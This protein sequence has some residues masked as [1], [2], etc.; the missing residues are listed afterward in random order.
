MVVIS[1][2]SGRPGSADARILEAIETGE[3]RLAISDQY[4][5][6]L[7]RVMAKPEVSSMV[8]E[9]PDAPARLFRT[10]MSIGLMGMLERPR[11]LDWPNLRDPND[12]W[13]LDLALASGADFIV[14]RDKGVLRDAPKSSFEALTP[15]EF[16]RR[17]E[18]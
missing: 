15:P 3:V 13:I 2:V 7:A 18:L 14:T 5:V 1:A 8:R 9:K 10:A 4:L 17:A 11:Q 16:I 12:A 6:E